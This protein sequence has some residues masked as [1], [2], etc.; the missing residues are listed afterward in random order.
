MIQ[1]KRKLVVFVFFLLVGL[2]LTGCSGAQAETATS[3]A[4]VGL[5]DEE[6]PDL[7][8]FFQ[9]N[10]GAF[11]LFDSAGGRYIRYNP[12]R[13]ADRFLPASTFKILN[14]LIGL[15]T[16]V[17]PDADYVIAWDGTRYPIASWNRDHTLGTAIRYSVVWYF[18]ELARRVGRERMQSCV[19]AAEYGNADIS[20][21]IDSFWLEGG[22]RISADEQVEF[23]KRLYAGEL[24]FSERSTDIVK[25]IIV[26]ET[27]NAYTLSG[28]TGSVQRTV[29]FTG[30]FVGYLETGNNVYFFAANMESDDPNGMASGE[31]AKRI[32][33]SIL[34]YLG[35]M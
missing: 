2:A 10:E 13:C 30:W 6:R 21:E 20:G 17:I 3:T 15:E 33:V 34:G 26:L 18:Q 11:V 29:V 31:S 1:T 24:P 7:G 25:E 12:P 16:G 35:V 14:A 4:T 23:L 5:V 32:A 22:L 27:S 28:K 9:G 19:A 8:D